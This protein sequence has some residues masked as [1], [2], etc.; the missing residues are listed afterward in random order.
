MY[1]QVAVDLRRRIGNGEW[2]EGSRI[3]PE[4][5]LGEE[6]GVSRVTVRQALAEL[7]KD[8]LVD[9]RRGSGTYV[10]RLQHPIVYDL[11]LGN[12]EPAATFGEVHHADVIDVGRIPDPPAEIRYRLQLRPTAGVVYMVRKVTCNDQPVSLARSWFNAE[13]VPGVERS[14]KLSGSLSCLLAEDYGLRPARTESQIEVVRATREEAAL[15]DSAADIPL[16]VVTATSYLPD[17]RPLE[18]SQTEWLGDRVRFHLTSFTDHNE[19]A[20]LAGSEGS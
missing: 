8:G 10:R 6:Y 4:L 7:D 12:G 20:S 9:R 16:V 17:G 3:P 19:H 11:A 18:F 2:A 5:D 15:L 1:F 13:T 14:R